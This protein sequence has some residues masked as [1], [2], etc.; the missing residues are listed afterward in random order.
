MID[1]IGQGLMGLVKA[2]SAIN[3]SN[4]SF[5]VCIQGCRRIFCGLSP[6]TR[7]TYVRQNEFWL[8]NL[9]KYRADVK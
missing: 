4:C 5:L 7:A 6:Q 9:E 8:S 2:E 1:A 3:L